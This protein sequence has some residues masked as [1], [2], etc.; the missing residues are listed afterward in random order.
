MVDIPKV[1]NHEVDIPDEDSHVE[2]MCWVWEDIRVEHMPH[3]MGMRWAREDIRVERMPRVVEDIPHAEGG[4]KK[5]RRTWISSRVARSVARSPTSHDPSPTGDFFSPRKEKKRLPSWG[6]RTRRPS[7]L[8]LD[9]RAV[10]DGDDKKQFLS[11]AGNSGC[12]ILHSPELQRPKHKEAHQY[13]DVCSKET[14]RKPN[15][16]ED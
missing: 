12:G 8:N 1:D 7:V 15:K 13:L 2:D 11:F 3:E 10:Y 5:K 4:R 6:G 14:Y 9:N 16:D